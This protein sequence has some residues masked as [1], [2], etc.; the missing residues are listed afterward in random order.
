M[1]PFLQVPVLRRYELQRDL[2]LLVVLV[3]ACAGP[4]LAQPVHMDDNFYPDMARNARTKPRYPNDTPYVF[5]GRGLA[6]MGSHSHPP[7]QTWL[8][9]GIGALA[10]GREGS[11]WAYHLAMLPVTLIAVIAFY[12]VA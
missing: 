12:F 2:A 6:D 8:L 10:G 4:F 9:A 3:A 7:L 1:L 5:E 11:E